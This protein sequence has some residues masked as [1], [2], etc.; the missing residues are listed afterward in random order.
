VVVVVVVVVVTTTTTTTM[1]IDADTYC[2]CYVNSYA[3]PFFNRGSAYPDRIGGTYRKTRFVRYTD[4]S[5]T[6]KMT[7]DPTLGT[8]GPLLTMEVDDAVQVTVK[9]FASRTYSFYPDGVL[10]TKDQEGMVYRNPDSRENIHTNTNT[11]SYIHV[12]IDIPH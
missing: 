2:V 1:M 3:A 5:F 9:N 12:H 4:S 6:T 10:L 7:S 8:L 11:H